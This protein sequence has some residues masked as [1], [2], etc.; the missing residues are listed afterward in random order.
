MQRRVQ[1]KPRM[2][3]IAAPET[4]EP[5]MWAIGIVLSAAIISLAWLS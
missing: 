4:F 3:V 1:V 5:I 2:K